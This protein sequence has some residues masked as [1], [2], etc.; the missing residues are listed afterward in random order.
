MET[1]NLCKIENG[2]QFPKEENLEKIANALQVEIKDLFTFTKE[3]NKEKLLTNI[4]LLLDNSDEKTLKL[5]YKVIN[6]I[7]N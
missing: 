6:A 5:T 3:L 1:I 4:Q 7:V 2:G